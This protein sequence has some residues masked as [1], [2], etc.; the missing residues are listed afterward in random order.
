[1]LGWL[2][3]WVRDPYG[4]FGK[5]LARYGDPTLVHLAGTPGTYVT[6]CPEGVRAIIGADHHTVAPWRPPSLALLT[7]DSLFLQSGE[8][9]AATRRM[10]TPLFA[11]ARQ[12]EHAA[13]MARVVDDGL[14]RIQPG[15]ASANDLA[16][17]LTLRIILA[18]IFGAA[19]EAQVAR[20]R[21]AANNVLDDRGPVALY[22][23][24]LRR[25]SPRWKRITRGVGELRALVESEVRARRRTSEAAARDRTGTDEAAPAGGAP[26]DMLTQLLRVR[27]PDGQPLPD[28]EIAV[29]L[30]DLVVAGH[31][32]TTVAVAWACYELCRHPAVMAR[33]CAE[34]DGHPGSPTALPYLAAVCLETL[35]VHPPLVFLTREV[36]APLQVCEHAVAPGQ[37][38]SIAV[39]FAHRN[40][41]VYPEPE[42]FRPER[43]L[44]RTPR[45]ESY[46]PFGGGSQRCLGATFAQQEMA[47]ILAGLLGRFRIR[48]RRDRPLRPKPRVITVAPAGGV[49]LILERRAAPTRAI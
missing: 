27:K 11:G 41:D 4:V 13:L 17:E 15:P 49:E 5:L 1:V 23:P 7:E 44:E 33:L 21:A 25:L 6:G 48:L 24:L 35:R 10:L 37:G 29:H 2:L 8:R 31:E 14:A 26:I 39:P 3:R 45:P 43:F 9:H 40:P 38:A 12:A 19:D 32:T 20:F 28:R 30:A 34:L 47:F 22:V 18:A 16:L 42:A 46:L 36:T